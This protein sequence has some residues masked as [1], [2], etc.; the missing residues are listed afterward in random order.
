MNQLK[1]RIVSIN[2][3]EHTIAV[4][5]DLTGDARTVQVD[6]EILSELNTGE[7]VK[8]TLKPEGKI[9]ARIQVIESGIPDFVEEEAGEEMEILDIEPAGETNL[10]E[11]MNINSEGREAESVQQKKN[12]ARG[13]SSRS[14]SK[15]NAG[16]SEAK[17]TRRKRK[18]S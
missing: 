9:A 1:G 13:G 14:K 4:E 18:K 3:A 17:S 2:P 11:G 12:P 8:I 6:L 7:E 5:D 10:D 16:R 15:T